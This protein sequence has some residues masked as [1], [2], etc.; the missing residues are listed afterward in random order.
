MLRDVSGLS[1]RTTVGFL[2]R[3]MATS[4]DVLFESCLNSELWSLAFYSLSKTLFLQSFDIV[5]RGCADDTVTSDFITV[6]ALTLCARHA[7]FPDG[8]TACEE[9]EQS[10]SCVSPAVL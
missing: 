9:W 7:Q 1:F 2:P 6:F 4:F 8:P 5:T 3:F 10:T